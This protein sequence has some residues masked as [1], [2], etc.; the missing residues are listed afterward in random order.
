MAHALTETTTFTSSVT[1]PDDG[2]TEN[3]ASVEVPFQALANRTKNLDT[4]L[5]ERG[6]SSTLNDGTDARVALFD[7]EKTAFDDSHGGN[8]Y[9]LISQWKT[10]PGT[11]A[12]GYSGYDGFTW[13]QNALWDTVTQTW[14]KDDTAKD[15]IKAS[16]GSGTGISLFAINTKPAGGGTWNDATW[17]SA[18][19]IQG[20]V[21]IA[22]EVIYPFL[23]PRTTL[24]KLNLHKPSDVTQWGITAAFTPLALADAA[25]TSLQIEMSRG[26]QLVQL[27]I[28]HKQNTTD[29]DSFEVMRRNVNT[30]TPSLSVTSL[31]TVTA[32]ASSG[33]LSTI[34]TLGGP[35]TIDNDGHEYLLLYTAAKANNELNGVTLDWLDSGPSNV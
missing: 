3:A 23:K 21:Q 29:Q 33:S 22:G 8:L 14:S 2:D 1:V 18:G 25:L 15:S 11:Y 28:A 12:R 17:A 26:C 16:L 34:L 19:V 4:R 27:V 24:M 6:I 32:A 30:S 7:I 10:S 20:G 13:T 35:E 31:G 9:K 5:G